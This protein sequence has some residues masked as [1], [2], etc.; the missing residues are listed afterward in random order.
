[1][2]YSDDLK[3]P[4]W[5][6]KRLERLQLAAWCCEDCDSDAK[7]LHVHHK[8][9]R[10]GAKP[11]EYEDHELLVLC[12]D[13]HA[14]RHHSQARITEWLGE[15]RVQ[16]LQRVLGYVVTLGL[17]LGREELEPVKLNGR[18]QEIGATDALSGYLNQTDEVEILLRH[19]QA[20]EDGKLSIESIHAIV[21]ELQ[22]RAA[23]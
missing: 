8:F 5:Q 1:M 17:F 20:G 2:A 7:T 13:C 4:R 3:D 10:R 11:W 9:Y 19:A 12:E 15:L 6:R 22:R 18:M 14:D 21:A 16:E 23:A